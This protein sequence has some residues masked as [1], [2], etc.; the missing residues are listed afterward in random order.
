M[1]NKKIKNA[2]VSEYEGIKFKSRLEVTV[3][4]TLV[5][6]GFSPKYEDMKFVLIKGLKPIV[7]FYT[8]GKDKNLKLD[9]R[10]M[11]DVTYTPDFTFKYGDTLVV[12]EVKGYA[13]DV[14]PLKR[15]LFRLLLEDRKDV[16]YFEIY[17]KRQ[18]LQA[19]EIIKNYGRHS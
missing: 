4:K 2:S 19:I 7:P 6:A 5:Q 11:T 18:L 12:M 17:T 15:K 8:K 9:D 1:E 10:K 14:Y 13:N 3:Y 16:L